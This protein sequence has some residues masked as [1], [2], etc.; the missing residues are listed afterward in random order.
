MK[1]KQL[2]KSKRSEEATDNG[3][4]FDQFNSLDDILPTTRITLPTDKQ[5]QQ[6]RRRSSATTIIGTGERETTASSDEKRAIMK[7]QIQNICGDCHSTCL[8]CAS[9]DVA[10]D[11]LECQTGLSFIANPTTIISSTTSTTATN[12]TKTSGLCVSPVAQANQSTI[13]KFNA[14]LVW[15]SLAIL[16]VLVALVG[17][18]VVVG[19]RMV[20]TKKTAKLRDSYAYD[21]V[22]D[23]GLLDD[24]DEE[25]QEEVL[26][27]AFLTY[28]ELK[29]KFRD[30]PDDEGDDEEDNNTITTTGTD[31]A[32]IV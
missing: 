19:R 25:E 11:C 29:N 1:R 13:H 32:R 4:E 24:Y 6:K 15:M 20:P 9:S 8:T 14:N 22:N 12:S 27:D 26:H 7:P 3:D 2:L 23:T 10:S 16:A 31:L 21:R 28:N 5:Q 17:V 30:D 18:I